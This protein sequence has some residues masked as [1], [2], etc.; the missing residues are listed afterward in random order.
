[1]NNGLL[2]HLRTFVAVAEAGSLTKAS[3]ATGTAQA[4]ISRQISALERHLRCKL[5]RR[6]TRAV[7]L[8][9]EGTAYLQYANRMLQLNAEAEASLM[10][11]VTTLKGTLRV[12]CSNAFGRQ[13]LIP[14]LSH[15]HRTHPDLHVELLMSDA[16]SQII[17]ENI[18]VAFRLAP[19]KDS[20]VIARVIGIFRRVLVASNAYLRARPSIRK[21]EDLRDHQCIAFTGAPQPKRWDFSTANGIVRV[22]VNGWLSVSSLEAAQS[23]VLADLGLAITPRWFWR[24][25][26]LSEQVQ[27]VLPKSPPT[28]RRIYAVTTA[29]ESAS[30]KVKLFTEFVATMLQSRV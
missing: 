29:R 16:P 15:W 13:L 25:T 1:M 14:S 20:R 8:S 17:A 10:D 19:L 28:D 4:T 30:G 7:Q 27:I 9:E 3:I 21:L 2:E 18:D 6:S 22:D 23:A 11:R 5:L 24:A 12:A 26:D